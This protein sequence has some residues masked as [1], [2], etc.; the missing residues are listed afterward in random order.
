MDDLDGIALLDGTRRVL[1]ARHNVAI[2]LYRDGSR[3]QDQVLEKLP[4]GN[5]VRDAPLLSIH[6]HEHDGATLE[7]ARDPSKNEPLDPSRKRP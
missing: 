6:R 3:D 5:A 7:P 2:D 4:H 1:G